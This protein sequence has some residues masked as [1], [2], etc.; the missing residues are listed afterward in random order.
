MG[1]Y[2]GNIV[3]KVQDLIS[4][5]VHV[6]FDPQFLFV[7]LSRKELRPCDDSGFLAKVILHL[8][9]YICVIICRTPHF[10]FKRGSLAT[11]TLRPSDDGARLATPG[12]NPRLT[13]V[14]NT[15][16]HSLG[17]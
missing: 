16:F 2:K 12:G 1:N 11:A 5:S 14:T 17:P 10:F 15:E 9:H 7:L 4:R 8:T 6:T 13:T 3:S